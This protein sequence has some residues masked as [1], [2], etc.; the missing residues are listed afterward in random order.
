MAQRG[1]KAKQ[2][3]ASHNRT[4]KK[5]Q[6]ER[7]NQ[8]INMLVIRWYFPYCRYIAPTPQLTNNGNESIKYYGIENVYNFI[9][10]NYHTRKDKERKNRKVQPHLFSILITQ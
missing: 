1:S 4:R 3:K 8:N 2:S 5:I 10:K 6:S 9:A 7:E